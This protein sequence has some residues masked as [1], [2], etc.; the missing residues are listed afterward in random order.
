MPRKDIRESELYKRIL[1]QSLKQVGLGPETSN[2][3][4]D[5][6]SISRPGDATT[7]H[8]VPPRERPGDINADDRSQRSFPI[9]GLS[10]DENHNLVRQVAEMAATAAAVAA[11]DA[12]RAPR[13][14]SQLASTTLSKDHSHN[15]NHSR[16][17]TF[18]DDAVEA[19]AEAGHGEAGHGEAG[20]HDAPNWSRTKSAVILLTATIAYAVIAEILVNT[21]DT[22]LDN[23][24]IEEKFLGI[25]LFALVPNTTEFL[26]GSPSYCQFLFADFF[27]ERHFFRYEWKYR[28]FYGDWLCVCFAGLPTPST[29]PGF[30]QRCIRSLHKSGRHH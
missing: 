17:P 19:T 7:P 1:G 14:I 25:T 23:V 5:K 26:V 6:R 22:V 27:L 2:G 4:I 21:V 12:A 29:L 10:E 24:D 15:P 11:R 20:G 18:T 3:S 28:P 30:I 9:P 13:R 8:L 16:H